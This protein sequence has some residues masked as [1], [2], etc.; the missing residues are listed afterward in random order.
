MSSSQFP[1]RLGLIS[2]RSP[3][4]SP[5]SLTIRRSS[6]RSAMAA[7]RLRAIVLSECFRAMMSVSWS[8][9]WACDAHHNLFFRADR[10]MYIHGANVR[11]LTLLHFVAMQV[12]VDV[13]AQSEEMTPTVVKL[14]VAVDT[15]VHSMVMVVANVVL[16][17]VLG[18]VEV[19][20]TGRLPRRRSFRRY[21]QNHL[22]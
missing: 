8:N 3:K 11:S 22:C 5:Q 20:V 16:S 13:G 18:I 14:H 9:S 7:A 12:T 15:V 1:G 10:E 21:L 17:A 19:M 6:I 4:L 2:P